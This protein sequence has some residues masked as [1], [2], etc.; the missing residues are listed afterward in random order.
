MIRLENV[1]KYFNRHKKNELHVIDNTSLTFDSAMLVALLGPSGS[2]KTT[3]LNVIGGL[4]NVK[5]GKVFVNG[6]RITKRLFGKIDKIRN[7][8]IGYIFQDYKLIDSLSVYDNVALALKIVGIKDKKEIDKRVS[9]VLER[10]GM[11]R[12]R[13]RPAGMLSGGERQR[14]GIARAIVKNPNIIIADEPTGNLDSKNSVEI[15][16][17]IKAISK[18]RLVIL[19]THEENLANFY[20]DR[21]IEISD[22]KVEKDYM[23]EHNRELDYVIDNRFYLKDFAIKEELGTITSPITIY[24]DKEEDIRLNIV[25]KNGNIYIKTL[26][27]KNIEVVDSSSNIEMIDEHY[28]KTSKEDVDKYNFDFKNIIDDNKKL[29]YSSI[30]NPITFITNGFKKVFNYSIIKKILLGGFVLSGIFLMFALSRIAAITE[31]R[32]S[33]FVSVNRNYLVIKTNKVS[34]D[35]YLEYEK[36]EG[37]DYLLPSNS[38]VDFTFFNKDYYQTDNGMNFELT[39]SLSSI[40]MINKD[41]LIAGNMPANNREIVVDK[42]AISKMYDADTVFQMMNLSKITDM[43]N[44]NVYVQGFSPFKIV[45]ITNLSSPSIYVAKDDFYNIVYNN[46][47]K[48]EDYGYSMTRGEEE[49]INGIQDYNL[50]LD[51]ITLVEGN[52]PVNDYEAIIDREQKEQYKIGKELKDSVNGHKLKVVGYYTSSDSYDNSFVN[53]NTIKYQSISEANDIIISSASKDKTLNLF[54]EKY[55]DMNINDIY[56]VARKEYISERRETVSVVLISSLVILVISLIEIFLMIRSSF[57][58]R[59]KEVGIYR[60]I[61][62]KKKDI[63][64]MFSGEAIAITT[65]A[66]VPGILLCAYLLNIAREIPYL[67]RQFVVNLPL[68]LV[69]IALIYL[70]NLIIGLVPVFK[71]I[72]APPAKILARTDV[73]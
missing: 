71:T 50:Y 43:L 24:S 5:S 60:A 65:L 9:Y 53:S 66:S 73:E 63:Y 1:N 48:S 10:V 54:R 51:K 39:G 28:K 62:V 45:G 23:N 26:D 29:K 37:V 61:G 52:L 36:V 16:N 7:L 56:N 58:S 18:D 32:D 70:F 33:D 25:V 47:H 46:K 34:V 19:V 69:A 55:P 30:F 49:H 17:I 41:D 3:L 27:D 68:V 67:S 2:G 64:I 15:M 59:I 4:D 11:Y 22:G 31:V 13:R 14:V 40:D 72:S 44:R 35:N 12:Y 20:A 6:E 8:N 57:L 42:L 38:I 21:I